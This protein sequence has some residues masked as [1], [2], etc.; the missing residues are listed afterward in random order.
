MEILAQ[1]WHQVLFVIGA[2]IVA[3]RLESE[4]RSLRKD[5]DQIKKDLDRRDTYVETVKLR[6]E[7]DMQSKQISSLWEF[8]NKL[9]DKFNGGK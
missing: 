1:Y 9:R 6:A 5:L 7:V 4:V 2:L 3:I 8:T